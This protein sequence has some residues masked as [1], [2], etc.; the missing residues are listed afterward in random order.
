MSDATRPG[1]LVVGVGNPLRGDDGVGLEV[2]GRVR[3]RARGGGIEVCELRDDP[4]ELLDLWLGRAGVVLIDAMRSGACPGTIRRLDASHEPLP[5]G[6]RRSI[7]SSHAAGLTEAIELGRALGRLPERLIVYGVEG[8]RY[9]VGTTVTDAL[10]AIV[11]T[12][13]ER[14]L[15]DARSLRATVQ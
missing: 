6:R 1:V 12:L 2:A 15:D 9:D 10:E 11:P 13:V 4:T 7:G 14:V 8:Q 5:A 3:D